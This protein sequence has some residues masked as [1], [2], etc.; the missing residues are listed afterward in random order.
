DNSTVTNVSNKVSSLETNLNSIKGEV[1]SLETTTTTISNNVNTVKNTANDALNKANNAQSTANSKEDKNDRAIFARGTGNDYP[2]NAIVKIGNNVVL[3]GQNRGLNIIA[4]DKI[5][6]DVK[7]KQ[8]Y[9]TFGDSNARTN[10]T[11]KI[12][13]LNNGDF[14]IIVTSQ[15][16]SYPLNVRGCLE[17]IGA[18]LFTTE[19]NTYRE[20]YALIGKSRLGKGNGIEMFIPKTANDKRY[21]DVLIKVNEYGAFLGAN[22]NNAGDEINSLTTEVTTVKSSVATLDV[23]L[24]GIT[25][26]VSS[27]ESTTVSLTNQVNKAQNDANTA[28]N[29]IDSLDIGGRN[30]ARNTSKDFKEYKAFTGIDNV[31]PELAKVYLLD[32]KAG[33]DIYI[34]L[35][36][37]WENIVA[38]SGRTPKA[39]TQGSGDVTSWNA[40]SFPSSAG[41]YTM[42]FG[43]GSGSDKVQYKVTLN[44]EHVKNS[45]W[46]AQVRH[47]GVQSGIVRWK[48]FKVEKGN[49]PTDWSPAPE[50]IDSAINSID[51]KVTTTNNKVASIETNL[52]SITSRVS[53]VETTTSNI[54]GQVNNLS[55]RMNSAEIKLSDSSIINTISSQFYKKGETNSIFAS[56]T[57]LNQTVDSFNFSLTKTGGT[58]E[59]LNSK[60]L[61]STDFMYTGGHTGSPVVTL[62]KGK[63]NIQFTVKNYGSAG[64]F[65]TTSFPVVEGEK[66]T[67]AFEYVFERAME[68]YVEIHYYSKEHTGFGTWPDIKKEIPY[69]KSLGTKGNLNYTTTVPPGAKWMKLYIYTTYDGVNTAQY[70]Y[71]HAYIDN[72]RCFRGDIAGKWCPSSEEM[73]T[74]N[75][76][77]NRNGIEQ[78]Y[79]NK[80]VSRWGAD[81]L[82][83]KTPSGV[84]K[85]AIDRSQLCTYNFN[86]GN[87][88][89]YFGATQNASH[90]LIFGNAL[91]ASRHC[92]FFDISHQPDAIDD[93]KPITNLNSYF[94]VN[95]FDYDDQVKG[96]HINKYPMYVHQN[97]YIDNNAKITQD[98]EVW[99]DIL[100]HGNLDVKRIRCRS[101]IDMVNMSVE[102]AYAIK[103]N[104]GNGCLVKGDGKKLQLGGQSAGDAGGTRIG[105][106][107]TY[108]NISDTIWISAYNFIWNKADWNWGGKNIY[109]VNVY[110]TYTLT[111]SPGGTVGADA[112]STESMLL[113]EDFSSYDDENNAVV[114]N[115][116]EA[117][118]SVYENNKKLENKNEQLKI[119]NKNLKEELAITKNALDTML[120]N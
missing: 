3:N 102:N 20:A 1:S 47:D 78:T 56:K 106:A 9:D 66:H 96:I 25:Q 103:F 31:C 6:L 24:K 2:G 115:I 71:A 72:L 108:G 30:L 86:D 39:W 64:G 36:Y 33:D 29:K 83:F 37:E 95:F 93:S 107:D 22:S 35:D 27:T 42:K 34:T 116:N 113:Q 69:N 10:F 19:T 55:T 40:G 12:E 16:A 81:A 7:F 54:N 118:K 58:N 94:R 59:I 26:R 21:A 61:N 17:K 73:Y 92:A 52:N 8:G 60:C 68:S 13:E 65:Q 50:D 51:N 44:A 14:I 4:L 43:V 109:D 110:G 119:E 41:I 76:K 112:I 101:G 11:N 67:L 48:N 87:F 46:T 104:S 90:S 97:L 18:T 111:G 84:R 91:S 88:L 53:N 114:V 49:K 79:N 120:M 89:S 74:A 45:F 15:D 62:F 63:P 98:L 105:V 85:L 80:Y 5:S 77:F 28:N 32:L 70:P 75:I 23:T 38:M 99:G 57:E 82:E 100:N 117:V